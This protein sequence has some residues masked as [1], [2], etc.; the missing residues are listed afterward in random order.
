MSLTATVIKNATGLD[1]IG[2]KLGGS[3][4]A[5]MGSGFTSAA[6]LGFAGF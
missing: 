4:G 6:G 2:F 5:S 1:A 3:A